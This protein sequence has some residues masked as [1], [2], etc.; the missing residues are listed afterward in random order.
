MTGY[1]ARKALLPGGW[2][3][4]VLIACDGGGVITAVT[5]GARPPAG[6]RILEGAVI[7]GMP[8]LHSHAFQRAMAGLTEHVYQGRDSFWTWRKLMYEFLQKFGPEELEDI[9]G[10]LYAEM[11]EAG[12]THVCE[13]HYL[14]NAPDGTAYDDRALL[15]RAMLRAAQKAG[16]GITLLPVLYA[17]GGCGGKPAEEG[18]KRFLS[19]PDRI[20]DLLAVLHK[21]YKDT[22]GVTIGLAFHSLRAV[23]P[24][25]IAQLSREA[26]RI[27]P[28]M[29]I[30]I[31][32]AEQEK[33]VDDCL[34]WSGKRPVEWLLENAELGPNWCLIHCTH[35]NEQE[36]L[37]LARSGAV[38]GLCPTTE[39]NL[40]DGF[41]NLPSYIEHGG[42]LGIGTDS[43]ISVNPVEELRWMEYAQRLK[44]RQRIIA[45]SDADLHVGSFLYKAA[46][47]GGARASGAPIG[48][49]ERGCR[50][51][52]CVLDLQHPLLEGRAD[53]LILDSFIFAAG[54]PAM[55]EIVTNA[56]L[57]ERVP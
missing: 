15:S 20:A 21:E 10:R 3:D 17:H 37:G 11:K 13:F 9:A 30:H 47:A 2:A 31:H 1:F 53:E 12:Y 16:I 5:K 43:H 18:Q 29:P 7:P 46:L 25:M 50:A 4:D 40:G 45:R 8:N 34:Q 35:M 52:F 6:T 54:L 19:T 14:H 36:T 32:A 49:I 51:D 41:F 22:P 57:R 26:R 24:E 23:T 42:I 48:R 44:F 38:A 56:D 28:R 55:K 27:D 39:A 33:E